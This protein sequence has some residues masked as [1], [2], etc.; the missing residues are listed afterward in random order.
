M[1]KTDIKCVHHLT[2][3]VLF[4]MLA[5]VSSERVFAKRIIYDAPDKPIQSLFSA[6]NAKYVINYDHQFEQTIII[7][8][9]CEIFFDGGS[10]RGDI[11]FC[12]TILN[13]KIKLQGSK[14]KGSIKNKVLYSEGFCYA[15]GI[16]DDADNINQMLNVCGKLHFKKGNYLMVSK[17]L[18]PKVDNVLDDWQIDT[19]IGIAKSNVELVGDEAGV[20]FITHQPCGIVYIYSPPYKFERT[21]RNIRIENIKFS[22]VNN[23]KDFWQLKHTIKTV[24][25]NGLMISNCQFDDFWGDAICLHSYGDT[26]STGERTRNSNVVIKNNY[27]RGGKHHNNRNG[28]SVVNGVNIRIENNIIEHTSR[29]DMPGAIDVEANSHVFSI[30]NIV[31]KSNIIRNCSGTAGGICINS[32]KLSAPAYNI[33]IIDNHVS[34]C[35]TGLAFV[36][37]TDDVT[38]N[39]MIKGNII[40][41]DTPPYKFVGNGRSKNWIFKS[42][43]FKRK[44]NDRIPG[45][46]KV[47]GLIVKNNRIND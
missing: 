36:V 31:I 17:H 44:T 15:D 26:P 46:I 29:S 43:V 40:E 2:S 45:N 33:K 1:M 5:I 24:G 9:D 35:T 16:H 37:K 13:G 19:H 3:I 47:E 8:N 27:I 41:S 22:S 18:A 42:N 10:L 32:P 21:V 11:K 28:I 4:F 14:L 20:T 30:D 12:N 23:G 6:K 34:G 39:Y 25:V 7:P 38:K